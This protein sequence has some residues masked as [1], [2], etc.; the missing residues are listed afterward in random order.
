MHRDIEKI[1]DQDRRLVDQARATLPQA[2]TMV[3]MREELRQFWLSTH[4]TREQLAS[5]LQNWCRRAE[6]SGIASLRDFSMRLRAA[7]V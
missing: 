4:R 1:P 6:S 5:D 2:D 7:R 3:R